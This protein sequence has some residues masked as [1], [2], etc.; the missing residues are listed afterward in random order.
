MTE[1][2]KKKK[3]HGQQER[4]QEQGRAVWGG[5]LYRNGVSPRQ[6]HPWGVVGA[7][8][9]RASRC[10]A[11]VVTPT[12]TTTTTTITKGQQRWWV[13]AVVAWPVFVVLVAARAADAWIFALLLL[14]L[15]LRFLFSK[16]VEPSFVFALFY[17]KKFIIDWIQTPTHPSV[18]LSK[19]AGGG[20]TPLF[21]LFY[22][23]SLFFCF[24]FFAAR[25]TS[26]KFE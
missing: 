18:T 17:P 15:R 16:F 4:S 3:K 9:A 14:L 22:C 20:D 5:G 25:K 7:L 23:F 19:T 2:K 10:V 6:E 11:S 24:L 21:S 26:H 8:A 13:A 12:I 1:W